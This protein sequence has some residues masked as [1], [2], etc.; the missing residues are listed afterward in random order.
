MAMTSKIV[1]ALKFLP[2]PCCR[3][4][5]CD[6]KPECCDPVV[7]TA[8]TTPAAAPWR[9]LGVGGVWES[10][11]GK[12]NDEAAEEGREEDPLLVDS[13][14]GVAV[15]KNRAFMFPCCIALDPVDA[16]SRR[17]SQENSKGKGHSQKK[18]QV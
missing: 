10:A 17:A 13:W 9:R 4:D 1:G 5:C 14:P 3:I 6:G 7:A 16:N 12:A 15:C 18:S 8:V 11:S 2:T